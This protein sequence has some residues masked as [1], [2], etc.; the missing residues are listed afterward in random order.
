MIQQGAERS[1]PEKKLLIKPD[2]WHWALSCRWPCN[3]LEDRLRLKLAIQ[4]GTS[5]KLHNE[6]QELTAK[7]QAK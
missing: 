1:G 4:E 7:P 2:V 5:T 3:K 6:R